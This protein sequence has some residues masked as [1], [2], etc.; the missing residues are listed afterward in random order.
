MIEAASEGNALQEADPA[1]WR[2]ALSMLVDV[3]APLRS[4]PFCIR[5]V[6]RVDTDSDE[7]TV[8]LTEYR[9]GRTVVN[10]L[11]Q[12]YADLKDD[13]LETFE[14]PLST[15]EGG[16]S[17]EIYPFLTIQG[18]RLCYY[19][20]TTA[21][22]YEYMTAFDPAPHVLE[23]KRKFS[24]VALR[25]TI[26]ADLQAFFWIPVE[27]TVSTGGVKANIPRQDPIVGRKEQINTVLEEII[28]IPNQ[29]GIVFGPGGVGKTALLIEI[30]RNLTGQASAETPYFKNIIWVSAKPN[31]Y[32]P[33]TT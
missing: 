31:Y 20:R 13:R 28:K 23:T 8:R 16:A 22:G 9:N 3:F 12:N 26:T 15:D 11:R 29:N 2:A 5:N 7:F 18:G 27:P 17:L 30:C 32:D 19:T 4:L 14:I 6:E 10:E 21:H 1:T 25:S 33:H 24:I